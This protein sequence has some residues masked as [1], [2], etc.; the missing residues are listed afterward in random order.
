MFGFGQPGQVVEKRVSNIA[1]ITYRLEMV[2]LASFPDFLHGQAQS[3]L[4]LM[5]MSVVLILW[6]SISLV[7]CLALVRS[8][9]RG[10]VHPA[11]VAEPAG[12]EISKASARSPLAVKRSP[13]PTLA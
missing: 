9:S 5:S 7:A 1:S 10:C 11:N 3:L 6:V 4:H 13:A 2:P 8:A 12:P